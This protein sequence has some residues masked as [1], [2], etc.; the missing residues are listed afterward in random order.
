MLKPGPRNLITD[1]AGIRVGNAQDTVLCSGTTVIL[2]DE[3]AV[4]AVD[5]RGGGPGT[6]ETDALDAENLVDAYHGLVLSGGSV[7]GLAAGDGVVDWLS[8]Q[9][10]GLAMGPK[11]IPVVP[12][13]ILF[14]LMNGGDKDWVVNPY[15]ALGREACEAVGH[16]F[17]LG[18]VGAGTGATAGP[19]KGGLGSASIDDGNGFMVGALM[20]ANPFGEVL[21]PGT[22]SF[23]AWALEEGEELGGQL[24][25]SA[26]DKPVSLSLPDLPAMTTNT[27]IG[28]VAVNAALTKSQARRVAMMAQD[29]IARAI[30]PAHTPFDGDTLFVIAAGEQALPEPTPMAIARLGAMAADCV[31]RA[32][33][34]GVYEASGLPN[35]PAFQDLD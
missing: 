20:A 25:P 23:W 35:W 24:A 34:R 22:K 16:D 11:A 7:F 5:V 29:G 26:I 17:A 12:G 28:V 14:D 13:A 18:S 30:R 21:M 10:R 15:P 2:P 8:E 6:R 33:M 27:T 9:G 31:A 19:I 1:V 4:M 32:I 3:P